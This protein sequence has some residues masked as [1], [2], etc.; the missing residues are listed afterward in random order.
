[1]SNPI[2]RT[3]GALALVSTA[4]GLTLFYKQRILKEPPSEAHMLAFAGSVFA[5]V[6]YDRWY[7]DM[8]PFDGKE[9]AQ[10]AQRNPG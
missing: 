4:L 8:W 1:V 9:Q 2:D 7:D 10:I 5:L 6:A 3:S